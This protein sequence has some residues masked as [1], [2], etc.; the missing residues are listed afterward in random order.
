MNDK[1][2]EDFALQAGF[3]KIKLDDALGYINALNVNDSS[4]LT[5]FAE[6]IINECVN[7]CFTNDGSK[8][9]KYFNIP[10]EDEDE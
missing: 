8:I 5:K 3:G 6:L 9:L 1:L 7:Q 4:R 2:I 10:E